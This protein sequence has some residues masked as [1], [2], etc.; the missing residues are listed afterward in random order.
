MDEQRGQHIPEH[1]TPSNA[2]DTT[3]RN[4]RR[5]A[6]R[7]L[8]LAADVVGLPAHHVWDVRVGARASEEDSCV[9]RGDARR[10][11]HHGKAD[12][13]DHGVGGDDWAADSVFVGYPC[14]GEHAETGKGV[15][16]VAVNK[17]KSDA[18]W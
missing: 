17:G 11:A 1:Q 3:K 14:G 7:T 9:L 8:P 12:D 15:C 2:S 5:T 13:G 10:P 6:E 18:W 4:Q 16:G